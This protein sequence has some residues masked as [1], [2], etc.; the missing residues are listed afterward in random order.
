[1]LGPSGQIGK[2]GGFLIHCGFGRVRVRLPAGALSFYQ[3][4]Q[5]Y[6]L[7]PL[8]GQRMKQIIL[9]LD[10]G[11]NSIG[12]ALLDDDPE[13]P[14][15]STLIDLGVRVFPEGVDNFDTSK[16]LSRNEDR[17]IAR[18]MRRQIR[19]RARRRRQLSEALIQVG[20]WPQ[21]SAEQASLYQHDP[22][23]LRKR[24]LVE[25]ME[26]FEIG[27]VLLHLNQRRGFL[28]NRKKD[29]GDKEVQGMLAEINELAQAMESQGSETIGEHFA[30]ALSVDPLMPIRGQHTHRGMFEHEFETI[31][32]R[33]AKY[34]PQLLTEQLK[35][36]KL[37]KQSY[38]RKP[39]PV[40][41]ER[42]QG[43]APLEAFGIYGSI[44]FQRP[45]YWPKSVVGLCEFEPKQKRCPRADRHAQRF[46]LLQEVNNLRYSDPD[47][48]GRDE[49]RLTDQ[50][51]KL[52]LDFFATH[53][54]ATF[55]QIRKKLGFLESVKFNLER[56]ERSALKGM[57]VDCLMAK[58]VSKSWHD[59][60]D[61]EK[62][63]IVRMLV[64]NEREDD[65]IVA[66]LVKEF[67]FATD[68]AEAALGV[69]F[70]PGYV[71]LSLMAIDKL[72]PHLERGLVY[73][74]A[75]DPEMSALHAAGYLRRDELR[76]RL[77]DKLPDPC[78]V[79]A[80]DLRIGDIP[81][82]VVKRALVELRKVVN[83][84]IREYGKPAAVH[85]EMARTMQMG[86]ERRSEMNSA[87]RK[88]EAEREA[89]AEVLRDLGIKVTRDS[90]LRHLLWLE[91][92]HE[93]VY[94]GKTIS[95]KQLFTGEADI[96]HILPYSRCLDDSQMN[97]VVCHR[98]CNHGK[99]NC[100]PYEWLAAS[101]PDAYERVCLHAG[102]LLKKGLLPYRK[103]RRFLQKELELDQFIA[104]QL[105][106]T[107]YIAQA[108]GEFLRCLF[109]KD[110]QVLGLKGQ[111]TAELRWQWGLEKALEEMPDSPAWRE[112]NN[113]VRPGDKNRADHRHHAIDA[114]VIALTNRSRLR[115]L[116]D[117][118]DRG[119][120]RR[121]GEILD[122]PWPTFRD[123]VIEAIRRLNVSYRVERKV[124]GKL[125]EE[126]LYGPTRSPGEWVVRKPVDSLSP[127]E[128]ERIRD[129]GIKRIVVSK[130][131]E[132]GIE[133]GRGKKVDAKKMKAALADLK[134]PSGV[135]IKKVRVVKPE[136]TIQPMREGHPDQAYVKPGSTHHLC[137]F[138]FTE[139]G[140][141]KREAVFVTMLEAMNRL[142]RKEPIV[143][144]SHPTRPEARFVMSLASRELVLANWKDGERLLV[145]KTAAST[146][147][148]IYFAD[149]LDARRSSDQT[150]YVATAN[151]LDARKVT[152]D[153]LGR[154]R[155]AND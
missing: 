130:L 81:N 20:L 112:N 94:C 98:K 93:C 70:P 28:S 106:D 29:R 107:G 99:G 42:R 102:T 148:Q 118:V 134:M 120:A 34:H 60:P 114:V 11:P 109:E 24:A 149:Q 14:C 125:H 50:Q 54:K 86:K 39:I 136:L 75:T 62:D 3:H 123:D 77:F 104:R 16:E 31:W 73:Q 51:R 119:G 47:A 101:E 89:A 9:G 80:G 91:Q 22:Y 5:P 144:R 95:Q 87:M 67:G 145:F 113:D 147:G 150:K 12:W 4:R 146:Q 55:D 103:Y 21:N 133:F 84:I 116:S 45:M 72:L 48:R 27:R 58:A 151:S 17:R 96:D 19:R 128:V 36:G 135:R 137:I 127:A 115:Q 111:L 40:W 129:P 63:A 64:D 108:T 71:N 121:H 8:E 1:M 124:A 32:N 13:N 90:I 2:G 52:L 30:K 65:A 88:R 153:P 53:E 117:I 126:T 57:V 139:N 7:R 25:R 85:L 142:K 79:R 6:Q 110:H 33:Q 122:E 69:D 132:A 61:E 105:T 38:P 59:R 74:A 97:K 37:G 138:E 66:K 100:T 83:A 26:P 155:W 15:E 43:M 46:R 35:Y 41:D 154:I 68:E 49:M 56:G 140:K 141:Q 10:L 23:T 44:F 131:E 143:Q 152:V 18:G 92:S 82:P 76:R 78:R